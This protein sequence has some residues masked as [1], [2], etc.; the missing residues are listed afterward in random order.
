MNIHILSKYFFDTIFFLILS[1]S[2]QIV[3]RL[4]QDRLSDLYICVCRHNIDFN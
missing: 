3:Q 2:H 1:L 4:V